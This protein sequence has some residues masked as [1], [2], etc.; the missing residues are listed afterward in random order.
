[1]VTEKSPALVAAGFIDMQNCVFADEHE[2]LDKV[3]YLFEHTDALVKIACAGYDLVHSRHTMK[4]RDQLFQWYKL[5]QTLQ[6]DQKIIQPG[7]FEPLKVVGC[8]SPDKSRHIISNG[9]HLSLLQRGDDMLLS[10]RYGEA[11]AA[12][13][14]CL[15]YM[16]RFPEARLKA[17]LCNLYQGD[18]DG[19]ALAIFELIQYALDEY[20]APD[21]D[22]VE[23]AYYCLALLSQG[24][25]GE[26]GRRARQFPLLR[27]TELDRVRWAVQVLQDKC[28]G[29]PL[30]L[31]NEGLRPRP[32]IHRLPKRG[33][34]AWI[35]EVCKI[36]VA[37][38]QPHL[39]NKLAAVSVNSAGRSPDKQKETGPS[40]RMSICRKMEGDVSAA[41]SLAESNERLDL[42]LFRY[43]LASYK[44]R[45]KIGIASRALVRRVRAK[46]DRLLSVAGSCKQSSAFVCA[47]GDLIL[48]KKLNTALLLL[49]R[50]AQ[51]DSLLPAVIGAMA[52]RN[53]SLDVD[54]ES[55]PKPRVYKLKSSRDRTHVSLTGSELSMSIIDGIP[56]EDND[57]ESANT[58]CPSEDGVDLMLIYGA[59][60]R[61]SLRGLLDV[62][63]A[64]R[65]VAL[66]H[67]SGVCEREIYSYLLKSHDY[68][69]VTRRRTIEGGYTIFRNKA[70][71][72]TRLRRLL[73]RSS[74]AGKP[75]ELDG[76]AAYEPGDSDVN[77]SSPVLQAPAPCAERRADEG[78]GFVMKGKNS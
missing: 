62:I 19:A 76:N 70:V 66:G 14:A 30:T 33:Q 34:E 57:A 28:S 1:M 20:K 12:Y 13:S 21:P 53:Y 75:G 69:V 74:T 52:N 71:C 60:T 37:C 59:E 2:V 49:G 23:W 24:R 7:V 15:G 35:T 6:A 64:S 51:N 31:C 3:A 72:D 73:F 45:R 9:L 42:G 10:G 65:F 61:A 48:K 50:E 54:I 47:I 25:L 39:A 40:A 4:Q 16:R 44:V 29:T 63:R 77:L 36:L 78:C 56:E 67:L 46:C 32:S 38:H 41:A 55:S 18:A 5:S 11:E 27:H 26:A 58:V 68:E 8:S 22:P 17:A 43:R